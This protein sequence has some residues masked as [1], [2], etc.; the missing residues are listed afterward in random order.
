MD[1]R[2]WLGTCFVIP[3]HR[4]SQQRSI[5][6]LVEKGIHSVEGYQFADGINTLEEAWDRGQRSPVVCEYLALAFLYGERDYERA[7]KLM[8]QAIEQGGQ[9]SIFVRHSHG[10]SILSAGLENYCVGKLS[11][12]RDR[13]VFKSREPAHD[14]AVEGAELTRLRANRFEFGKKGRFHLRIMDKSNYEFT[15]YTESE[16]ERRLF[17]EL[18]KV[19]LNKHP[20]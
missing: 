2:S 15:P 16:D 10:K 13:L 8:T 17:L 3:L 1:R 4:S 14:F 20:E 5:S 7:W 12:S 19:G 11:I 9:A 6:T 18:L